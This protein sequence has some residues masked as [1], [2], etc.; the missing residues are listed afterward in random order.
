MPVLNDSLDETNETVLLSLRNPTGGAT[1]GAI[2]NAVLTILDNDVGGTIAFSAAQYK[3]SET[4]TEALITLTRIG[5]T[6]GGVTV[7]YVTTLGTALEGL[8]FTSTS[9]TVFFASNEVKKTFSLPPWTIL[10]DG[11]KT[12]LLSLTNATGGALLGLQKTATLTVTDNDATSIALSKAQAHDII[13]K[14]SVARDARGEVILSFVLTEPAMVHIEC[15]PDLTTW[16]RIGSLD[17]PLTKGIFRDTRPA[18]VDK[19]FY[20]LILE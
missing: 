3:A 11:S 4:N 19:C 6:A 16:T 13:G 2:S 5:G 20:R 1:L 15:S 18:A 12:I 7:D 9:G 10:T 8:D 17:Q 14:L